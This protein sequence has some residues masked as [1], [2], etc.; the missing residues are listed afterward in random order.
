[1]RRL[2]GL[3]HHVVGD[4]DDDADAAHA[5]RVETFAHPVGRAARRAHLED[6]RAVA[7]AEVRVL[8][9]HVDRL[10]LSGRRHRRVGALQRQAERGRRLARQAHHA[11]AVGPV[12]GDLEVDHRLMPV[13]DRR[14][15][16]AACRERR[17]D[18]FG[19]ARHLHGS[20]SQ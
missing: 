4:V 19:I 17:R 11:E 5:A 14:D 7:R 9:R 8:D 20:Q 6:L 12:R 1:V 10:R 16:E 15:L 18:R 3:E 13:L 2:P